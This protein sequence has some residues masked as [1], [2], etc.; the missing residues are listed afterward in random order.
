MRLR[1]VSGSHD[2]QLRM[3]SRG[4]QNG[5]RGSHDVFQRPVELGGHPSKMWVV[6]AIVSSI[7]S[8]R[9]GPA[10]AAV[11]TVQAQDA[12]PQAGST[13]TARRSVKV[14]RA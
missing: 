3:R 8:V 12:S 14:N 1:C 10:R 11:P 6:P 9:A 7:H 2:E 5:A 4:D 13:W